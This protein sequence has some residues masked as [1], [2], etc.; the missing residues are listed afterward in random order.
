MARNDTQ[1][2]TDG[3]SRRAT[4]QSARWTAA[5]LTAALVF[6]PSAF[7]QEAVAPAA[8]PYDRDAAAKIIAK[9]LAKPVADG[10]LVFE[11]EPNSQADREGLKVGD[12]VTHYDAQPVTD[13][14]ELSK[15][16]RDAA[17]DARD[18]L[19]VLARRGEQ[20]MEMQF[21]PSKLGVRLTEVRKD[22]K[23]TLWR[24][25]SSVKPNRAALDRFLSSPLRYEL[26]SQG[27]QPYG[28]G[29]QYLSRDP[30]RPDLLV[31][32]LQQRIFTKEINEK[33]DVIVAFEPNVTLTPHAIRLTNRDKFILDVRLDAAAGLMAG[34]R[35]GVPVVERFPADT[36]SSYLAPL[37]AAGLP[38]RSGACVR[39]SVLDASSL[40]AA[41][42]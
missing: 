5:G 19:V 20:E 10:L 12:V 38:Q 23:R 28:W 21:S 40:A 31:L 18:H 1:A 3:A 14:G 25:A 2:A 42:F 32:R 29:R 26:Y 36:L 27:E 34:T 24:G 16:A 22:E 35:V 41:P 8:S 37:A 9:V 17:R 4:T 11:V 7:A 13:L 39:C 6:L 15:L 33:R 30:V